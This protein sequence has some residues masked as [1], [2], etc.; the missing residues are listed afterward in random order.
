MQEE[1]V[2]LVNRV[3]EVSVKSLETGQEFK[4]FMPTAA[5]NQLHQD[6]ITG[7]SNQEFTNC[8]QS[9]VEGTSA[10]YEKNQIGSL[11]MAITGSLIRTMLEQFSKANRFLICRIIAF[12][13]TRDPEFWTYLHKYY[14]DCNENGVLYEMMASPNMFSEDK[15]LNQ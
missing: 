3:S 14:D 2:A 12:Y 1:S 5:F 15:K 6:T 13:S 7:M 9:M 11:T 4:V 8:F 10:F